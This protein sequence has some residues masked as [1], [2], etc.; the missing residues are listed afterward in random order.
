MLQ[1]RLETRK[2][3]AISRQ[4]LRHV[5]EGRLDDA[6]QLL[7]QEREKRMGELDDADYLL[8][9]DILA[10]AARAAVVAVRR[11]DGKEL[12][13]NL[14]TISIFSNPCKRI[15]YHPRIVRQESTDDDSPWEW[16][17]RIVVDTMEHRCIPSRTLRQLAL[18]T[19]DL[20]FMMAAEVPGIASVTV[21]CASALCRAGHPAEAVRVV[22]RGQRL[23]RRFESDFERTPLFAWTNLS[24]SEACFKSGRFR[25]GLR[26]LC[27]SVTLLQKSASHDRRWSDGYRELGAL[28]VARRATEAIRRCHRLCAETPKNESP[29]W[30]IGEIRQSL[31]AMEAAMIKGRRDTGAKGGAKGRRTRQGR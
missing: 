15:A 7:R 2:F 18:R 1:G 23:M 25:K 27:Q 29:P 26:H 6:G 22:E 9:Q 16:F 24:L 17:E 5:R 11:G 28:I 4:A 13:A 3:A 19:A 14:D 31:E 21:H 20:T 12:Q 8:R 10:C 30:D